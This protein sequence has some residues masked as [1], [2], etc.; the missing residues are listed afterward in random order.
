VTSLQHATINEAQ[1]Q[2]RANLHPDREHGD[3]RFPCLPAPNAEGVRFHG[4]Q[5]ATFLPLEGSARNGLRDGIKLHRRVIALSAA[6]QLPNMLPDKA[7]QRSCARAD[8]G[9][10]FSAALSPFASSG[11][12]QVSV[13]LSDELC[14]RRSGKASASFATDL[15]TPRPILLIGLVEP[16]FQ[17]T[18]K[19]SGMKRRTPS[20]A[21]CI[22]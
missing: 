20:G 1:I 11:R 21:R 15:Q 9:V 16:G 12:L 4:D 22:A 2:S 3:E 14:S 18:S 10:N 13:D 8:R 19:S 7:A 5:V 17:L 6:G